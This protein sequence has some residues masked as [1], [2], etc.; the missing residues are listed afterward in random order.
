VAAA[1]TASSR[2]RQQGTTSVASLTAEELDTI[3]ALVDNLRRPA[4]R[5]VIVKSL[6]GSNARALQRFGLL[7]APQHG[8]LRMHDAASLEAGIEALLQA[9]RLVPKGRKYPTVWPAGKAVRGGDSRTGTATKKRSRPAVSALRRA[10]ERYCRQA[11]R[12]LGWKKSYMVLPRSVMQDIEITRPDSMWA[13]EQVR[14]IGATKLERFGP[15][16]LALV[17]EHA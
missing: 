13:L 2:A 12:E 7:T 17:R 8:A 3:A 15:A 6:R 1:P 9:G 4:G 16:I 11:A 14:G 5:G 10:L